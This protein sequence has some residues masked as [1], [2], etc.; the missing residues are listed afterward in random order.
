MIGRTP[1]EL[2]RDLGAGARLWS[3]PGHHA[4]EPEWWTAFSCAPRV[5]Y[6]VA[7][8]LSSD[9]DVLVEHCIQPLLDLEKPGI[10]MLAGPGL[11]TGQKLADSGWVVVGAV[12]LMALDSSDLPAAD[13]AGVRALTEEDLPEARALLADTYNMSDEAAAAAVPLAAVETPDLGVWG[14]FDDNRMV[15]SFTAATV[16]GLVVVWSMVTGRHDQKKGYGRRLLATALRSRFEAG[17]EGSLLQSS[18][19]AEHLYLGLGYEVVEYWQLWSRPRWAM[20]R[21]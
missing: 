3:A 10:I 14:L 18:A 1:M 19:R 15:A 5:D 17:A 8:C 4:V 21:A 12:P 11:A 9:N 2:R 20:G 13:G 6:N 7:C 16:D